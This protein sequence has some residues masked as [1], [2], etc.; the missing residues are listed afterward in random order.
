VAIV[1][2]PLLIALAAC[3][4]D[5]LAGQGDDGRQVGD[6]RHDE[7]IGGKDGDARDESPD[8][9]NDGS[10]DLDDAPH[11][12]IRSVA[13]D[14]F[15]AACLADPTQANCC[16]AG[17]VVLT[18]TSGDDFWSFSSTASTARCV[19]GHGGHDDAYLSAGGDTV[20][21]GSGDDYVTARE[22]QNRLLGGAGDD[23]LK[24]GGG[25]DTLYGGD[26]V[27]D[28][29]AGGGA[30]WVDGGAGD[31][32]LQGQDGNDVLFPSGTTRLWSSA[33]PSRVLR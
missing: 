5:E 25:A 23:I 7:V 30:D 14:G 10:L 9:Q 17:Q 18:G 33:Q 32:H 26:D 1:S 19:L 21:F 3:G 15:S 4:D 13:A 22:G 12:E 28:L 20:L 29:Y 8:E 6:G 16:S 27:D 24:S 11:D 2:S 31:D